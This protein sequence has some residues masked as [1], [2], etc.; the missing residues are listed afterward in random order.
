MRGLAARWRSGEL[1][2]LKRMARM[3]AAG[4]WSQVR[5]RV[6]AMAHGRARTSRAAAA[7]LFG[8]LA[9]LAF[10]SAAW[11]AEPV[12]AEASFSSAGGFARLVIKFN[13]DVTSE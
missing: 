13:E 5:A 6:Q 10:S 1:E 3:A 2:D 8:A 12:Q 7:F 11:A 4:F 9:L